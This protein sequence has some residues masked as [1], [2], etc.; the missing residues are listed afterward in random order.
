[1]FGENVYI[2]FFQLCYIATFSRNVKAKKTSSVGEG[3]GYGGW[4]GMVISVNEMTIKFLT[5]DPVFENR[6]SLF[7]VVAVFRFHVFDLISS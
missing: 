6:F 5:I 2:F 4:R 1:M 7:F 3:S